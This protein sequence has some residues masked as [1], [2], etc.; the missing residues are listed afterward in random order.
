MKLFPQDKDV[1]L[2]ETGFEIDLLERTS[3]SKQLSELV[4]KIESPMVLALDDKWGSGKTYFLKRWVTAHTKENNGNAITVYFDAFESDYLSDPLVAI[5]TAVSGRIPEDQKPSIKKWKVIA[6]K[7]AKPS[8]GIALAVASFGAQRHL[9]E[10]GDVIIDAA[11]DEASSAA[12]NLWE[13]EKDR[14]EAVASF[15][16]LLVDFTQK[17]DGPIVIVVD[18]LDRCRPDYA[19]LVLEVIKHFFSAPRVHFIL[20][21]NGAALEDSVK[22]RYGTGIDAES[23]L[24]K[25]ISASFSLPRMIGAQGRE[26]V[27]TRYAKDLVIQMSLPENIS[28]RCLAL[29]EHVSKNMYVSLRDVGRICSKIALVPNEVSKTNYLAGWIDTLCMLIVASVIDPKLHKKL[30]SASASE[31]EIRNFLGASEDKTVEYAN[32]EINPHFD[33]GLTVWLAHTLF[34]CS[35]ISLDDIKSLPEWKGSVARSFDR[36]GAPDEP[37]RIASRIQKEWV[38]IFKL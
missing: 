5:I 12:Q 28:K 32:N 10:I 27:V 7:L 31:N 4:E 25:F 6:A 30:C 2:Y 37:K 35:P 15:K 38:E 24:R 18:E 16:E 17:S 36:F 8:F 34:S 23:Y 33:H 3:I 14:S 1:V 26:D 29:I 20:G 9:G 19:L 13:A 22:A 11:R 21:V